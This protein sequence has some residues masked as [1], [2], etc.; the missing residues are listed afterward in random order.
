MTVEVEHDTE[1]AMFYRDSPGVPWIRAEDRASQEGLTPQAVRQQCRNNVRF[2][3]RVLG[4]WWLC[5]DIEYDERLREM[6]WSLK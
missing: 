3:R 1:H 6:G 2:G 4:R 5:P